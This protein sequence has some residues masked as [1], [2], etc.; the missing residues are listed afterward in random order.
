MFASVCNVSDDL[1]PNAGVRKV[2]DECRKELG[3]RAA[4]AGI[5]FTSCFDL[6]YALMLAE[7]HRVFP[8]IELVGC[9]TDGEIPRHIGFS[10][11]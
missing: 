4:H 8:G 6:D 1:D 2:A 10:A 3:D 7:I 9:T 11:D 5:F